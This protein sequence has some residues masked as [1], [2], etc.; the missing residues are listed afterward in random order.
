MAKKIA[1]KETASAKSLVEM[2]PSGNGQMPQEEEIRL[3]AYLKWEAAGRPL[4]DGNGFWMEAER[5]L[6][7]KK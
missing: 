4:G 2:E 7:A 3:Q 6:L 5:E 1:R